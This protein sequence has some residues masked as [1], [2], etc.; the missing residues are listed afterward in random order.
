MWKKTLTSVLLIAILIPIIAVP[1]ALLL[2]GLLGIPMYNLAT[3]DNPVPGDVDYPEPDAGEV[4][5]VVCFGGSILFVFFAL[6]A[7]I[8]WF[9]LWGQGTR[10]EWPQENRD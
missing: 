10:M 1:G 2:G 9:V 3:R 7:A 5:F 4:E 6:V 8:V